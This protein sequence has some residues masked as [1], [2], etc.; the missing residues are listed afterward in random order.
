VVKDPFIKGDCIPLIGLIPPYVV[1][2]YKY[3]MVRLCQMFEVRVVGL[4]IGGIINHQSLN[5]LFIINL[6]SD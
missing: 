5:F 6:F 3:D 2:A 1:Q 4:F